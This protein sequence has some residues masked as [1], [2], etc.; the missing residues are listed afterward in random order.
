MS[1]SSSH[2]GGTSIIFNLLVLASSGR[3]PKPCRRP[4]CEGSAACG[5]QCSSSAASFLCLSGAGSRIPSQPLGRVNHQRR[6]DTFYK[7]KAPEGRCHVRGF[8]F[9]IARGTHSLHVPIS[10]PYVDH[11]QAKPAR[12]S[13]ILGQCDNAPPTLPRRGDEHLARGSRGRFKTRE[14][15][16]FRV[17]RSTT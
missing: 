6:L 7:L 8:Y 5:T 12:Q 9:S 3:L 4:G 1:A 11:R 16:A 10:T 17:L 14:T 15:Q 13:P 2:F